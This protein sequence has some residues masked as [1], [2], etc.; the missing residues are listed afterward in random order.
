M[1]SHSWGTVGGDEETAGRAKGECNEECVCDSHSDSF[2][3]THL[4]QS[5]QVDGWCVK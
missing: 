1:Y 2:V 5:Q 3:P 4:C